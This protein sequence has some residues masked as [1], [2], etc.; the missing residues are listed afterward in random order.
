MIYEENGQIVVDE[1]NDMSTFPAG[2]IAILCTKLDYQ[3]GIGTNPYNDE[4]FDFNRSMDVGALLP[5]TD[6]EGWLPM[7]VYRPKQDNSK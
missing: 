1:L 5:A 7:P 6:F 4:Y 2:E 3:L